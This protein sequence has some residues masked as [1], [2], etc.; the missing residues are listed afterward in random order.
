MGVCGVVF[1]FL[2]FSGDPWGPYPASGVNSDVLALPKI[3]PV[4]EPGVKSES[5]SF[6]DA[7]EPVDLLGRVGVCGRVNLGA[8]D[9]EGERRR[10]LE[11]SAASGE[12]FAAATRG[13][14]AGSV[15]SGGW[16]DEGREGAAVEEPEV[17]VEFGV[18]A[19]KGSPGRTVASLFRLARS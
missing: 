14:T 17:D 16:V 4:A 3:L 18:L 15:G 5:P 6:P 9:G 11:N 10:G 19:V 12:M 13:R 7:K 2:R 1:I 8:G